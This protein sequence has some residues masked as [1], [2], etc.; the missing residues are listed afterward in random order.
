[1]SAAHRIFRL[2]VVCSLLLVATAAAGDSRTTFLADRLKYPPPAGKA[3]D[4]RV[5]T[6]AALALGATNDDA[7]VVPLCQALSDPSEVVRQAVAAAL[8]RLGR[9]DA[10]G[11]LRARAPQESNAS[12]KL[13]ISRAIE[14]IEAAGGG[15]GDGAGAGAPDGMPRS[16]ANAR[17][18]VAVSNITNNTGRPQSEIERVVQSAVRAKLE[19]LGGY[20]LAPPHETPDGARAAMSKR[21]LK[22]YYLSV[23]VDRFDYSGGNLRVRVKM[24]VFSYPGKDLRGEVPAGLTQTG[25]RPGDATAED[26]LMT[27]AAGRAAELFAQNFQ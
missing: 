22:G 4:F 2:L 11:C 13:Q 1:L 18:Y 16:I 23:S 27:M 9:A 25:V 6:N 8:R 5:R 15:E 14:A 10:L 20:Q 3:D 24:A 12:V 17:F 7:A 19:A 21:K 26:N